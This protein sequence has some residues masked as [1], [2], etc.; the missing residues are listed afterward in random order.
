MSSKGEFGEPWSVDDGCIVRQADGVLC[1]WEGK[2]QYRRRAVVCVN[3]LAGRDPA[4]V[5]RQLEER[6]ELLAA[7]KRMSAAHAAMM[8]HEDLDK[9]VRGWGEANAY[10]RNAIAKAEGVSDANSP[11]EPES[12][13]S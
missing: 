8:A 9:V 12:E 1:V 2:W 3:A 7:C 13:V 11:R 5:Q 10:A 6:D 4:L